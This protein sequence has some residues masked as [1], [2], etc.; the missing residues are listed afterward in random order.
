MATTKELI[1]ELIDTELNLM[2]EEDPE[3][4]EVLE[5]QLAN[6]HT[7]IRNK[8]EK[9]DHFLV[10]VNRKES[11]IDA[12]IETYK[13]EIERLKN[14]KAAAEKT[15]SFFNSVLLPL[16]IEEVGDDNGVWQTD[17]AR[18]KLYE[19]YGPL[20]I[21]DTEL[22]DDKYKNVEI[23]EK[24]DKKAARADAMAADKAGQPIP[25]GM[26]INKIKRVR[27]S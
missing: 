14:R 22:V 3:E 5:T 6:V 23:V 12:E 11:L 26:R 21:E 8:V 27:R 24:L 15:K 16:V 17:T 9:L 25:A 10:E 4:K 7:Q 13:D 18:Y 2:L 19:T 1:G 20:V